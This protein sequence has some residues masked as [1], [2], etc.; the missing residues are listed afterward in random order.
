MK[1]LTETR[2]FCALEKMDGV[3]NPADTDLAPMYDD[4]VQSAASL[5]TYSEGEVLPYFTLHYTRLQL[6]SI[7]SSLN[8]KRAGEKCAGTGLYRPVPIVY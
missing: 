5:C 6:E 4:F 7:Q 3:F 8:H 2:L 1:R